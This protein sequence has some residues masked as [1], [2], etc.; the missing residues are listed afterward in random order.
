MVG[1]HGTYQKE[2]RTNKFHQ[3]NLTLLIARVALPLSTVDDEDFKKFVYPLN[4]RVSLPYRKTLREKVFQNVVDEA[5]EEVIM[6]KLGKFESVSISINL[7]M[8]RDFKLTTYGLDEEFQPNM[9]YLV[10]L[11]C[12]N[13]KKGKR[14]KKIWKFLETKSLLKSSCMRAGWWRMYYQIYV[15]YLDVQCDMWGPMGS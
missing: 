6:L 7:S 2:W 11:E 9:V 10:L 8:S 5:A 4:A 14:C 12:D 15:K 13:R 1:T 3:R